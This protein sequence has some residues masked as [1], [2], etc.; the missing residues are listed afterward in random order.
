MIKRSVV[1][2]KQNKEEV[3]ACLFDTKIVA[4]IR[5]DQADDLVEVAKA[6][7]AGGVRFVE[8]T[9]TVPNAIEAI[10]QTTEEL[11]DSVYIGAG[12]VLDTEQATNAIEAGASYVVSPIYDQEVVD[13]CNAAGVAVMPGCITPSEVY[14]AWKGGA[15]VVKIF[16]AGMGGPSLFKD[17]KGPFPD[18]KIMPTGGVNLQTAGEFIK[19]GACAVGVGGALAGPA[20][21]AEKQYRKITDNAE[22]LI[23]IASKA[24]E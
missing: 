23:D 3:L 22:T 17:L 21:I 12:T 18:I 24:G 13:V 19:S 5:V 14:R 11:G 10:R 15:D 7:L 20:L 1:P 4:V 6:L 8:I 2:E 9:L 16:P